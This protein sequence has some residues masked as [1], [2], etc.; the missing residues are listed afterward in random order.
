MRR[1]ELTKM[2]I[3]D[4]RDENSVLTVTQKQAQIELLLSPIQIFVRLYCK[5]TTYSIDMKMRS[6]MH[7]LLECIKLG[8]YL[9]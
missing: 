1:D 4:I 2:S 7:K 6:I 3:D 9:S 8:K 5:Y